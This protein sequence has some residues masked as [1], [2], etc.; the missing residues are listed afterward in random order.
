MRS[1]SRYILTLFIWALTP[2]ATRAGGFEY[3]GA[4]AQALGRG[5]AVV[6][7][8]NHPMLLADNP[9]G[10]AELRGT[11][12]SVDFNLA[13]FD[14]CADLD[15]HYGWRVYDE[16]QPLELQ[17]PNAD[18]ARR[19]D[20][21]SAS[22]LGSAEE[23]YYVYPL[24]RIC[25]DQRVAPLPQF[26]LAMRLTERLG[27]GAGLIFPAV[28]STG[29]WGGEN[30]I[31]HLV[32]NDDR[33]AA[34]RYKKYHRNIIG[35]F[36]TIG[37]GYRFLDQVRFGL[38]LQWGIVGIDTS[39]NRTAT[40]LKIENGSSQ[41][42]A[43]DYDA[44]LVAEV[45]AEDFF[46]PSLTFST[47]FVPIDALDAVIAFKW[48][49]GFDASGELD[50]TT[51][52]FDPGLVTRQMKDLKVLEAT[53]GMP[54]K[55]NVGVRYAYRL[56]PRPHGTGSDESDEALGGPIHDALTDELWDI[57]LDAEYQFNSLVD[58]LSFRIRGVEPEFEDLDGEV[59]ASPDTLS[60]FS[61]GGNWRDQI[62]LRLGGTYNL[63]RG[64][65]GASAGVHYENRGLD[66]QDLSQDFFWPLE[67]LGLHLGFILRILRTIDASLSYAH[68]FQETVREDPPESQ[69]RD[70]RDPAIDGTYRSD[71]DIIA[72]G[73]NWHF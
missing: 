65:F 41:Y 2:L 37:V 48:Q 73:V 35:V 62:S 67:R 33:P 16:E 51:G 58:S 47:H 57:E 64:V 63:V 12:F 54:W 6:A 61:L 53:Q 59:F 71:F 18:D 56:Q 13:F 9:A 24:D 39:F 42:P 8:A 38:A 4:G 44:N 43:G 7:R 52:F 34:I 66:P 20:I 10:L 23:S 50:M 29:S 40:A 68:I 25:S 5:G 49:D 26:I 28:Q 32:E 1:L 46:I 22:E 19:L 17:D 36:P 45:H 72:A 14:A 70:R 27:V 30:G 55:F 31:I 3:T 21:V 11:Q 69:T 15:D 60:V